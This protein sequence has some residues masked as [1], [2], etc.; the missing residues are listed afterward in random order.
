MNDQMIAADL[1]AFT[2]AS[3]KNYA[4]AISETASQE[5]RNVLKKQL[6]DAICMHEKITEYMVS[7][8]FY[9][10]HDPERQFQMDM[11]AADTALNLK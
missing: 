5:V 9:N 10:A 2:K 8:G 1:L 4:S 3:M 7:K 11:Q 6:D